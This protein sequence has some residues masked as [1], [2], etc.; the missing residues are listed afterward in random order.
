MFLLAHG[1]DGARPPD[2]AIDRAVVG[3]ET[4]VPATD[5]RSTAGRVGLDQAQDLGGRSFRSSRSIPSCQDRSAVSVENAV[6]TSVQSSG[7]ASWTTPT[8]MRGPCS[9]A[10]RMSAITRAV[11]VAGG[12]LLE[13]AYCRVT[14][15]SPPRSTTLTVPTYAMR[16]CTSTRAGAVRTYG[17]VRVFRRVVGTVRAARGSSIGTDVRSKPTTNSCAHAGTVSSGRTR[18]SLRGATLWVCVPIAFPI[19]SWVLRDGGCR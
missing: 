13:V 4:G 5:L 9:R 15:A 2:D 8:G 7:A 10:R 1:V 12:V 18:A 14:K 11:S 19:R 16:Y 6:R 17:V 3:I